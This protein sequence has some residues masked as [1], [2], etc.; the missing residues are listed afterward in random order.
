MTTAFLGDLAAL[1]SLAD[2]VRRLASVPARAAVKV[3]FALEDLVLGEFEAGHDPYGTPW[4]ALSETT[5]DRGRFPP[6]LT[7]TSQM[8]DS[9]HATPRSTSGSGGSGIELS[10]DHPARPHQ[11]GWSGPRGRGPARPIF[12]TGEFPAAW[13]DRIGEAVAAA[14]FGVEG[15]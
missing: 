3:Q 13:S 5:I 9:F 7:D 10:I 11:T 1:G 4:A 2:H 6:P 12:P 15:T 14:F 8:K